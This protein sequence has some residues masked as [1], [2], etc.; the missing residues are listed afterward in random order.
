VW[1]REWS[2]AREMI[3]QIKEIITSSVTR[4]P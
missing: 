4:I 3:D 1:Q 2:A